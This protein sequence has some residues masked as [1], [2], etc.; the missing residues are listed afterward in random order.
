VENPS[1]KSDFL[2]HF[3]LVS[4]RF[5]P[6]SPVLFCF[7]SFRFVSSGQRYETFFF[8]VTC[9]GR[10]GSKLACLLLM[11][12][13]LGRLQVYMKILGLSKKLA[14]DKPLKLNLPH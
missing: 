3:R 6:F 1:E 4:F 13:I 5:V 11:V 14:R 2:T 7:V 10:R 9:G 12:L 8:F